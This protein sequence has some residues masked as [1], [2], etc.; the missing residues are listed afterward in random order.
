MGTG[1]CTEREGASS[2]ALSN[3]ER[4]HSSTSPHGWF[5][6]PRGGG[7]NCDIAGSQGVARCPSHPDHAVLPGLSSLGDPEAKT[8]P[9]RRFEIKSPRVTVDEFE[10]FLHSER[11]RHLPGELTHPR[12]K[13]PDFGHRDAVVE[14]SAFGGFLRLRRD[15]CE[16]LRGEA[17]RD[18]KQVSVLDSTGLQH[19]APDRVRALHPSCTRPCRAPA[20]GPHTAG[21]LGG[22]TVQAPT[23]HGRLVLGLR[24]QGCQMP[25]VTPLQRPRPNFALGPTRR[26]PPLPE[27]LTHGQLQPAPHTRPA[28]ARG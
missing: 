12:G 10:A 13:Q 15:V 6:P 3:S 19:V 28:L 27:S 9:H 14:R 20:F 11:E 26:Q 22:A 5:S 1:Q 8:N 17:D 18:V 7:S 21:G 2:H 23:I 25:V 16:G 24:S 4:T